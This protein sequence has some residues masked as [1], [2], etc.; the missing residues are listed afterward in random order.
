VLASRGIPVKQ[1]NKRIRE[2]VDD[3][4]RQ[5]DDDFRRMLGL[6]P[7]V[8]KTGA[9]LQL[10]MLSDAAE[11][12]KQNAL[13]WHKRSFAADPK[14]AEADEYGLTYGHTVQSPA[15]QRYVRE[16]F[17]GARKSEAF[18]AVKEAGLEYWTDEERAEAQKEYDE[19]AKER[20]KKQN[21]E[22][23]IPEKSAG[24]RTA[25]DSPRNRR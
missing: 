16:R 3:D 10:I 12:K 19:K 7:S 20:R 2:M 15:K 21:R 18:E 6:T 5:G 22:W 17:R 25:P 4:L 9:E 24:A 14:A 13:P 8:P 1:A 23:G 11:T